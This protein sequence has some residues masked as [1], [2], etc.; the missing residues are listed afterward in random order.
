MKNCEGGL[1][2]AAEGSIFSSPR[3]QFF[4]TRTYTKP[5]YKMFFFSWTELIFQ[6]TNVFVYESEL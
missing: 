4:T 6:I 2:N 1:E 5:A 3:S